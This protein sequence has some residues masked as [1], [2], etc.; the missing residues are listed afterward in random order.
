MFQIF[1]FYSGSRII[2]LVALFEC[3]AVAYVFGKFPDVL[4]QVSKW[5]LLSNH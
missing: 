4:C 2:L 1:D 3:I 5:L